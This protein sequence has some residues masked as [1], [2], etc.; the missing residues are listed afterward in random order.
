M[1]KFKETMQQMMDMSEEEQMER[2][3][4]LKPLCTCPDCP[5][6]NQCA[7]DQ[8]E[9]VFCALGA[10]DTC[11]TDEKACICPGCPVTDQMGLK[12]IYFCTRDTERVQRGM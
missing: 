7:A 2:I 1:D 3:E 10:S 12:N 11:I 8:N 6:Y 5:S 4:E 9:L